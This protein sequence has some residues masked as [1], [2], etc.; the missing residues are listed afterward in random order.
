MCDGFLY[1]NATVFEVLAEYGG[2]L[3]S[4]TQRLRV[5]YGALEQALNQNGLRWA[6]L[7]SACLIVLCCPR[8]IFGRWVEV[9]SRWRE[10][11]MATLTSELAHPGPVRLMGY[12]VQDFSKR[13]LETRGDMIQCQPCLQDFSSSVQSPNSLICSWSL[14]ISCWIFFLSSWYCDVATKTGARWCKG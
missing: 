13:R 12:S 2:R 3:S 11:N 5:S 14:S 10:K 6:C 8:L 4:V 9:V 1:L 7:Q